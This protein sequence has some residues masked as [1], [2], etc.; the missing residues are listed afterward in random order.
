MNLKK[1]RKNNLTKHIIDLST[2]IKNKCYDCMC[3]QKKT[4]CQLN[5]C[6]LYP[7]RPWAKYSSS[8]LTKEK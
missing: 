8:A 7:F 5:A 1:A 4:D 3:D 6:P 2:A